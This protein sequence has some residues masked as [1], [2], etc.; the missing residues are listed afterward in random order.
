MNLWRKTL[1]PPP[2]R[3]G[4]PAWSAPAWSPG[5]RPGRAPAPP[6]PWL[7]LLLFGLTLFSVAAA[8]AMQQGVNPLQGWRYLVHLVEGLPFAATLLGILAVHEFG[9]YFAARRWGVRASLP[10]FMP[11]PYSFLGTLGAVIRIQSPIPHKRALLDI[12]AAGPLAGLV[13]A[14]AACIVGLPQSQ[15]VPADYFQGP[16]RGDPIQLGAP[17]LFTW[18]SGWLL[19]EVGPDQMLLLGPV[20]F[21]GWVGLFITAFNLLP[22]GQLDGGH[23]VYALSGRWHRHLARLTFAALLGLGAYGIFALA[24]D[25]PRGW[26]GWLL[27]AFLLTVFG[28][29]HPPPYNPHIPL[30]RWRRLVG[31]LCLL[32]FGLC[33]TPAPFSVLGP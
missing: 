2:G 17:L 6:R 8:G 4:P 31:L 15:V 12:G 24:W 19:P 29:H 33:F 7:H 23:I 26:L 18:L 5:A 30:D 32:V 20:A 9:H 1:E 11:L 10:Y 21:A 22:V 3:S 27:L 13:V 16:L 28:R 14:V 25:L